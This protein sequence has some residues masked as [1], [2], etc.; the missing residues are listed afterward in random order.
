MGEILIGLNTKTPK[1]LTGKL[2][3][4][5]AVNFGFSYFSNKPSS[6][7]L[8]NNL[9]RWNKCT[10]TSKFSLESIKF[11]ATSPLTPPQLHSPMQIRSLMVPKKQDGKGQSAKLIHFFYIVYDRY[12]LSELVAWP[13]YLV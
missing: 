11:M 4:F 9:V 10:F 12:T 13:L 5:E 2:C 6:P 8:A 3:W 7:T 1:L